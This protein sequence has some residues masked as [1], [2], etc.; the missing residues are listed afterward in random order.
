[1]KKR[2]K[3]E[4]R[5]GGGGGGK[6]GRIRHYERRKNFLEVRRTRRA[7][8]ASYPI[9]HKKPQTDPN[10]FCRK[11]HSER[12]ATQLVPG[13]GVKIGRNISGN[14]RERRFSSGKNKE[15]T[16]SSAFSISLNQADPR[17]QM[18]K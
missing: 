13:A 16:K 2:F 1:L 10:N 18:K 5:T 4:T 6:I 9:G 17:R 15:E 14:W 7:V 8:G 12:E 3:R 11:D